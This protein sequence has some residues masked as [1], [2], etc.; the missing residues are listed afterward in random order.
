M[1][2]ISGLPNWPTRAAAIE[3]LEELIEE[4][5]S[6]EPETDSEAYVRRELLSALDRAHE[7]LS[8]LIDDSSHEKPT[9]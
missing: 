4:L 1:L 8:C 9:T 6:L 7:M 2:K 3:K 5:E